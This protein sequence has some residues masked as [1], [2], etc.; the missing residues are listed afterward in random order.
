MGA[1]D[2]IE[3]LAGTAAAW[4]ALLGK[5]AE[6]SVKNFLDGALLGAAIAAPEQGPELQ[7]HIRD[8]FGA[9]ATNFSNVIE[10]D[11]SGLGN[12][13]PGEGEAEFAKAMGDAFTF[14]MEAHLTAVLAE[15][16]DPLKHIGVPTIAALMAEFSGFKEL[17]SA[18]HGPLVHHAIRVPSGAAHAA[19]FR[20]TP[21]AG[22][23][24]AQWRA[25]RI[26]GD[27]AAD[28]PIAWSGLMP[29]Y[30]EAEK[31]AAYS[32]VQPRMLATL[33]QDVPF[34]RAQVQSMLEFHGVR[35]QDLPTLLDGLER[36]SMKNVRQAFMQSAVKAAERG[37]ITQAELDSDLDQL[38]FSAD[39]KNFVHLTVA[40]TKLEQLAE[41]YRK[42]VD[43]A[44]KFGLITDA[45]YVPNLESIGIAAADAQAHYAIVSFAK[46]GRALHAAELEAARA[47]RQQE[48][49]AAAAAIADYAAG[50]VNESA[51]AAALALAGMAPIIIPYVV[52]YQH[53]RRDSRRRN[54]A[55]VLVVEKDAVALR[56]LITL[57]HDQVSK[58]VKTPDEGYQ[59]LLTAGIPAA[60]AQLIVSAAAALAKI[61][62]P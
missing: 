12:I 18:Y 19:K 5:G 40:N 29:D 33:Y 21:P 3:K 10:Q 37:N 30:A 62:W 8:L 13:R 25:R 39:A 2:D 49:A 56:E 50:N 53:T 6:G 24:A 16:F 4:A 51:L 15:L 17:V 46:Q 14:G 60:N 52:A 45:D 36:A 38:G 23:I 58:K 31:A 20:S 48:H 47:A 34:P 11:L 55:G 57:V 41:L 35:P 42:S 22:H 61:P 7:R 44:Y 59:E 26:I 43:E 28:D 54:V 9:L 1:I 27:G 32:A